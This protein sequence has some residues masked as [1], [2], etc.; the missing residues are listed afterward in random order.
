M[1]GMWQFSSSNEIIEGFH[2]KMESSQEERMGSEIFRIT[3]STSW[4]IAV[5][6]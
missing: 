5:E 3:A 1:V 6:P 2:T 4:R